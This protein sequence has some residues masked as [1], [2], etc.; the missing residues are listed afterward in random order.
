MAALIRSILQAYSN[1]PS[2]LDAYILEQH[3]KHPPLLVL[4]RA[5]DVS[6]FILGM[7]ALNEQCYRVKMNATYLQFLLET[8][9][10][11]IPMWSY[12]YLGSFHHRSHPKKRLWS[13]QRLRT[14]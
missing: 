7:A 6:A 11:T 1:P 13:A 10:L 12:I 14:T 5:H 2:G 4:T 9:H 8:S 3:Q